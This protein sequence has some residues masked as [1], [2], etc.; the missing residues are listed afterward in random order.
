MTSLRDRLWFP[1]LGTQILGVIGHQFFFYVQE[2]FYAK[3]NFLKPINTALNNQ[4][5]A[6]TYF[7]VLYM[8]AIWVLLYLLLTKP[9]FLESSIGR[10]GIFVWS[11]VPL[12]VYEAYEVYQMNHP[13]YYDNHILDMVLAVLATL[14]IWFVVWLRIKK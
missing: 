10:F 11:L 1:M 8:T 6:T 9:A 14:T 7:V 2:N 12:C 3:Q 4:T 5:S 13:T